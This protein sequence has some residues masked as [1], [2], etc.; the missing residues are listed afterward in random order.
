[1]NPSLPSAIEPAGAL[2]EP[3]IR[4]ACGNDPSV[5]PLKPSSCFLQLRYYGS[6]EIIVAHVRG[7]FT[8]DKTRKERKKK[9]K[10]KR[11]KNVLP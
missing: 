2:V 7:E 9:K 4:Q 11:K 1:M 6:S 5:R 8:F 10:K 3:G